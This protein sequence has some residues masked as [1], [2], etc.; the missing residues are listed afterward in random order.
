MVAHF[1]HLTVVVRDVESAKHFFGLLGFKEEK[2]VA[3]SGGKFG[4]YMAIHDIEAEH[5][6]GGCGS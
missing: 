6:W 2:T 3:I 1:D 4:K 5:N